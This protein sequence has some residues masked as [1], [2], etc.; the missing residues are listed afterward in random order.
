M[1][2]GFATV[3]TVP[4]YSTKIGD[5]H[6]LSFRMTEE[7]EKK[8]GYLIFRYELTDAE[9]AKMCLLKQDETVAAIEAGKLKGV[10]KKKARRPG[11]DPNENVAFE[12]IRITAEPKEL[13]AFLKE[14]GKAAF[15]LDDPG[16][17][18]RVKTE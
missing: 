2:E 13:A 15:A 12:E 14:R 5:E 6:Y 9:S 18:R 3:H 7:G 1:G 10:V 4:L 17:F 11:A 8:V 16:V